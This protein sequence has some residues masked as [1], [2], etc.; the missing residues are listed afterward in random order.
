MG[1][2]AEPKKI[3]IAFERSWWEL[4]KNV[5]FI[6]FE[7]LCKKLWA[8]M[9]NLPHAGRSP[10]MVKSRDPAF[11]FRKFLF[12][13]NSILNFRESYQIWEKL[14]QEQKSYRQKTNWGWKTPHPPV[15]IGLRASPYIGVQNGYGHGNFLKASFRLLCNSKRSKYFEHPAPV[16]RQ[17]H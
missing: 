11:K 7:P 4:F 12:L 15:L 9:S 10:N 5:T 8:F 16:T 3:Y 1:T 17:L 2:S 6:E 14:A 13:P